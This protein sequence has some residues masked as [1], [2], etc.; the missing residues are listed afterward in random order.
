MSKMLTRIWL[1]HPSFDDAVKSGDGM[2]LTIITVHAGDVNINMPDVEDINIPIP[3]V[4]DINIPGVTIK[5]GKVGEFNDCCDKYEVVESESG[6]NWKK[7]AELAYN[8]GCLHIASKGE[9]FS[10]DMPVVVK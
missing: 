7:F 4:G 1:N 2:Y 10:M 9:W 6:S 5:I 8:N 3:I